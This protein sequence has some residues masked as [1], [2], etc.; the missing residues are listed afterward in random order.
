MTRLLFLTVF[1]PHS[2][3]DELGDV[4]SSIEIIILD[5]CDVFLMQ[6]WEHVQVG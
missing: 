5:Q 3:K 1:R 6:N 2:N 4:L